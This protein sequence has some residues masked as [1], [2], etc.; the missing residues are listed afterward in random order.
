MLE[1]SSLARKEPLCLM[2]EHTPR[3]DGHKNPIASAFPFAAHH[4]W[5]QASL[6]QLESTLPPRVQKH[7][8]LPKALT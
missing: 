1:I 4:V 3:R 2:A 8:A 5:L 6:V 7:Y